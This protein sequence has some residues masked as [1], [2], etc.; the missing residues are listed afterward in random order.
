MA[1]IAWPEETKRA[2]LDDQF[3]LQTEHYDTHF[4]DARFWIV[5]WDRRPVG[6]LYVHEGS[7]T[8]YVM[9]IALLPP[10]RNQG[11]G[12]ALM[13]QAIESAHASGRRVTC[14][15]EFNNPAQRLYHRLGFVRIGEHGV[16]FELELKAPQS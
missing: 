4:A 14:H 1:A 13:R 9:D 2:F 11:I 8:V 16:Y 7:D 3:R 12:G 5:E 10:Y 6:R 15:V